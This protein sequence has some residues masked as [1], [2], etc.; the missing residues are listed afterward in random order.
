MID[1]VNSLPLARVLKIDNFVGFI[2]VSDVKRP[3]IYTLQ[4]Q[5]YSVKKPLGEKFS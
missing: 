4:R 1:E 3:L 5:L 2:P